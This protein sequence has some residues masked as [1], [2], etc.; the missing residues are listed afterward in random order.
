MLNWG[1]ENVDNKMYKCDIVNFELPIRKLVEFKMHRTS[2]D[3]FIS[4]LQVEN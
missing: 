1:K 3:M 2:H 4:L